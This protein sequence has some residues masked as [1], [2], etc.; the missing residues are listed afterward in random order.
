MP[1]GKHRETM[2][3]K[4]PVD[5]EEVAQAGGSYQRLAGMYLAR[6]KGTQGAAIEA[7]KEALRL[8]AESNRLTAQLATQI[9]DHRAEVEVE[10][11]EAAVGS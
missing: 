11:D 7:L 5:A 8:Q 4:I 1:K 3:V 9:E 2:V 10:D 6:L